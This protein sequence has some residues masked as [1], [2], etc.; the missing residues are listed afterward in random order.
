MGLHSHGCVKA[1][2]RMQRNQ[3][4]RFGGGRLE[5][6]VMLCAG[7]LPYFLLFADDKADLHRWRL[8][9]IAFLKT[10]RLTLHENNAQP[11]PAHTG[12]PFLGFIVFPDYRRL[13]PANGYAFQRRYK[14]IRRN[15][16]SGKIT[17]KEMTARVQAWVNHAAHGDTWG[18]RLRL[19]G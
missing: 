3:H 1:E 12:V 6:Q 14:A 4:V 11:R 8:E 9:I 2:S 18:L 19:L 17:E 16:E 10:L 5:T 13:K 15:L 7:R